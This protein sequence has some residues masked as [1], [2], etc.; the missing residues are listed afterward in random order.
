MPAS[1]DSEKAARGEARAVAWQ[2]AGEVAVRIAE[3]AV[4]VLSLAAVLSVS[5]NVYLLSDVLTAMHLAQAATWGTADNARS[6]MQNIRDVSEREALALRL[7]NALQLMPS[8][9]QIVLE[10]V[11]KRREKASHSV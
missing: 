5:G 2:H 1:T 11:G 4:H 3:Q 6:N 10:E 7:E 8:Y 9:C